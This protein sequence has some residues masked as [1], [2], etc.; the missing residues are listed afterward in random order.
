MPFEQFEEDYRPPEL[1][2]TTLEKGQYKPAPL[3]N[4]VMGHVLDTE[5]VRA[6][7]VKY[8]RPLVGYS[9]KWTDRYRVYVWESNRWHGVYPLTKDD[10]QAHRKEE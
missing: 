4:D 7:E 3:P 10:V 5:N 2:T 1:Y 9:A 6:M 8:G